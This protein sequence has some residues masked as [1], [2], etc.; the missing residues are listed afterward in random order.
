MRFELKTD[1]SRLSEHLSWT[2]LFSISTF[3]S[4]ILI[5]L[6]I[7][8]GRISKYYEINYLCNRVLI[9]KSSFN[10]KRLSKLTKQTNKQKM[11]DLCKALNRKFS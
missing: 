1:Q 6:S 10:F 7:N 4:V 5:N 2:V 3:L 11:W 8:L 9:E